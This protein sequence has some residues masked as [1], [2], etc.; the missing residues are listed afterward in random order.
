MIPR[1]KRAGKRGA[2]AASRPKIGAPRHRYLVTTVTGKEKDA[3][4]EYCDRHG[5][6]VSSFLAG[7][8]LEDAQRPAMSRQQGEE[9]TVTLRLSKQDLDKLRIFARRQQKTMAEMLQE[10]LKPQFRK[11]QTPSTLQW[12][13]LRCWL[14]ND[15][16]KTIMKYLDKNRLSARTYLALLALQAIDKPGA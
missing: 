14:S 16:H 9:I 1:K 15:E 2:Y 10:G 7:L 12:E 4:T 8:I 6:S 5:I 11:R 3:I 13:T